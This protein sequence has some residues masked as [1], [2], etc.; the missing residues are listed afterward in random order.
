MKVLIVDDNSDDRRLLRCNLERHGC[1]TV[2]EA[3][4]GREG[5]DLVRA[6]KPDLI[7]SDALMPRMDGFQFLRT[8]KMDEAN[9][10]IPF[11][12]YS[13]TY[14]GLQDAAFAFSLGA[15]AYIHKPMEPEAFWKEITTIMGTPVADKSHPHL[16]EAEHEYLK[17]YSTIVAA[18]LEA[19]VRALE[20]SLASRKEIEEELRASDAF[21]HTL[22]AAIPIPVFYKDRDERYLGF[23]RAYL[24]FFG[25]AKERLIGKTAFETCPRELAEIYHAKDI[26][27]FE[28]GGTQQYESQILDSHGVLHEVIFNK[29][30]FT[31]SQ[32]TICGLIGAILDITER[33]RAEEERLAHLRFFERMDWVNRAIQSTNDLEW[34]MSDVLDIV[35]SIFD[36]DRAFLL[37][38]CDPEAAT[39]RVP[40]ERYKPEYTGVHAQRLEMA[41]DEEVANT[42]QTLLETDGPVQFDSKTSPSFPSDVD[43]RFGFHSFMSMALHPKVGKPWQFGMHQCSY[44]RVWTLEEERLFQE[45]GRRLSDALTSLLSYRDLQESETKYRRIVDTAKEGIWMQGPDDMTTFVNARMAE[46][47]GYSSEEMNERPYTDFMFE[48]DAP[49]HLR[50]MENRHQGLPASYE[51][52]LR[53]K[54]GGTV[55][56]QVSAVPVL[57]EERQFKG[58][59]AMFTDITERKRAVEVLQQR[60]MELTAIFEN[61]PFMMMLLDEDRRVRRTNALACLFMGSSTTEMVGLRSGEALSCLHAHDDPGGCGFGPHCLQCA[62]CCAV[63]DTLKTGQNHSQVE[64][65]LPFLVQGKDQNKSFLISTAFITVADNPMVLL[66]LQD[67]TEHKKLEEQL[68][69][70]QKMEAIGTLAGGVAHDFN[71]ILTAIIGFGTLAKMKMQAD[72]PQRSVIDQILSASERATHLTQSLLTFSRKQV[73]NPKPVNLNDAVRNVEK[74]LRR[75]IGEDI[76]LPTRISPTDLTVMADAGQIE[77]VLMNLATNARDAMP[78]GGMIA[79]ATQEAELDEGFVMVHGFGLPGKYALITVSDDG[80]GMDEGTRAKIFEPFFTTKELGRGTGLGLAIVYG[81]VKQHNGYILVYSEPGKGTTFKIY[82][83]LITSSADEMP[84]SPAIPLRGGTET[85]LLAEDDKDVRNL[86]RIVLGDFGYHIIEAV[87]G[88]DATDK[89]HEHAASIDLILVDVVMPKKSGL[90]VYNAAKTIRPG[91]KAIFTS[92]YTAGILHTKGIIEKGLHYL[93]KPSSPVDLLKKIR[94]VLD[95]KPRE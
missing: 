7:I 59:C 66:S 6:N 26:E 25:A 78:D 63:L 1:E 94:E 31:D 60:E 9:K 64:A 50:E 2:I 58:S 17:K 86:T 24:E 95:E 82:L 30:V 8:I 39:W 13:A 36:C 11:V 44:Q 18:K 5:L 85:I 38:P 79:I 41:M 45:I 65:T 14:T 22:L 70:A 43:E 56:T 88:Q 10:D 37:Y 75:L 61:A 48:E 15:E 81:I 3:R 19:K 84:A 93:S 42:L 68:R 87:D 16:I 54:D 62:V 76:E 83:P 21:L 52:R 53:R 55:W 91:I 20:E 27:L 77:Q 51:R 92:G 67:I 29:A 69:Q 57:D 80:F 12:F 72:D 35:L 47:L 32:G 71:N 23:N 73:L 28:L 4:D 49:D 33:K 74:F 40:M 90:D 46:M 34:M 89:F